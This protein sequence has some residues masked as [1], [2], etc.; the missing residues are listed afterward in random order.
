MCT[1]P[2]ASAGGSRTGGEACARADR[3]RRSIPVLGDA[4]GPHAHDQ[5]R[6]RRRQGPRRRAHAAAVP[7]AP[8]VPVGPHAPAALARRAR[9]PPAGAPGLGGGLCVRSGS[10][11]PL[12]DSSG[13]RRESRA[14][15][16]HLG[17]RRVA[18]RPGPP[19]VGAHR[20]R[21]AGRPRDRLRRQAPP[22]AGGWW[23]RGRPARERVRHR[24]RLRDRAAGA[25]RT[26]SVEPGPLSPGGPQPGP[27]SRAVAPVRPGV[28][29]RPASRQAGRPRGDDAPAAT[30]LV[31]A[32]ICERVVDARA[33]LRHDAPAAAGRARGQAGV[34]RDVQRRVPRR[35]RWRAAALPPPRSRVAAEGSA[36]RPCRSVPGWGNV[37]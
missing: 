3:A 15:R 31:L 2:G 21:R 32:D 18:A 26:T 22:C 33:D 20:G 12:A 9:S 17:D 30:V 35:L 24:F 4:D 28:G 19:A 34:R 13:T 8:R 5:G 10:S 14:R 37:A 1:G 11:H 23:C 25:P 7:L 6:G 36:R 27:A 29:P 16:D